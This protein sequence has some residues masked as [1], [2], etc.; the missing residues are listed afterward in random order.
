MRNRN[1]VEF[2]AVWEELHNDSR[3]IEWTVSGGR[4]NDRQAAWKERI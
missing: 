4:G 3:R 1:T 2:L